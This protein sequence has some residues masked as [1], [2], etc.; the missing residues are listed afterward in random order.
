MFRLHSIRCGQQA[1]CVAA[2]L[3]VSVPAFAQ[4][5]IP[6]RI[7]LDGLTTNTLV[8]SPDGSIL[9]GVKTARFND[10][11]FIW[12][13]EVK[14]G[15]EKAKFKL[16]T[17]RRPLLAFSPDGKTIIASVANG[18][19]KVYGKNRGEVFDV[20]TG[21]K[22]LTI[23]FN[24]G[25]GEDGLIS[26][27]GKTLIVT[28]NA[29]SAAL[30]D[31]KSGKHITLLSTKKYHLSTH[32]AL[33]GD[34][35][36]LAVT[37]HKS[38]VVC[39]WDVPGRKLVREIEVEQTT[40]ISA[41]AISPKGDRIA[42]I[43]SSR[44]LTVWDRATGKALKKL[45]LREYALSGRR[46]LRF[47]PDGKSLVV[48]GNGT[49]PGL[50]VWNPATGAVSGNAKAGDSPRR[51]ARTAHNHSTMSKDGKMLA[52]QVGDEIQFWLLP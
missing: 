11:D 46:F 15:K 23:D 2:I 51:P 3:A 36:W 17:V 13:W 41:L 44:L 26:A 38:N 47:R 6:V 9:A 31:L 16:S 5:Q 1:L 49:S 35:K 21:Q 40:R 43:S 50:I 25:D 29:A 12:L 32:L 7:P 8:F 48:T 42:T 28:A 14:S 20:K 4:R 24:E 19:G 30:Y 33:S 45:D 18:R 22:K 27:D 39:V 52:S 34:D 37:H 10:H